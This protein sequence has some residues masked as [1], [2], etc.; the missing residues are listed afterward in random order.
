MSS[1]IR[2]KIIIRIFKG[3]IQ[4]VI[5]FG[6]LFGFSLLQKT[7]LSQAAFI[8][9]AEFSIL[10]VF[11]YSIKKLFDDIRSTELGRKYYPAGA[12][13]G[14]LLAGLGL[15]QSL[16]SFNMFRVWPAKLAL[17]LFCGIIGYSLSILASYY[18]ENKTGL[19]ERTCQWLGGAPVHKFIAGILIGLYIVY[20]RPHMTISLASLMI[21]E[22]VILCILTFIVLFRVGTN[23]TKKNISESMGLG[24]K[25]HNPP[26]E[27]LTGTVHDHMLKVERLFINRGDPAGLYILLTVLMHENGV[28]E[29]NIRTILQSLINFE[30]ISEVK[31]DGIGLTKS[32]QFGEIE[33]RQAV[34]DSVYDTIKS[35]FMLHRTSSMRGDEIS[36]FGSGKEETIQELKRRFID[37]TDKS[38]LL[39]RLIIDMHHNGRRQEYIYWTLRELTNSNNNPSE[40]ALQELLSKMKDLAVAGEKSQLV[41]ETGGNNG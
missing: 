35:S 40:D 16:V 9:S 20:I 19:I 11:G 33:N 14:L 39:I 17:I 36:A 1:K 32:R 38:G 28:H 26:V 23:L 22:W 41:K 15:W 25:Q 13:A 29:T 34:I 6:A 10:L 24:W 5:L 4:A 8:R 30:E 18:K 31:K 2:Q 12:P 37:G 3:L 27:R 21:L 7:E